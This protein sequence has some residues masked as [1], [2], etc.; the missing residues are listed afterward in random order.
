ML[1][2]LC[3]KVYQK[4]YAPTIGFELS[5]VNFNIENKIIKLQIWDTC[6][7]EVYR[8]IVQNFYRSSSIAFL[9]YSIDKYF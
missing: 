2:Y 1:N 8:S 5:S 7:Q 4:N 3:N 9:V 6:G